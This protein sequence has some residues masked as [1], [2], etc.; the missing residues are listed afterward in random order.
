MLR[1]FKDFLI[2]D[3]ALALAVGIIIGKKKDA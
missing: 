3:N 2:K 1:E